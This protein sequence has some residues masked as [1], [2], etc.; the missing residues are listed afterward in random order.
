MVKIGVAAPNEGV[1]K[2]NFR[3]NLEPP[4]QI[5]TS[6]TASDIVCGILQA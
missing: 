1:A 2:Q 6:A 5:S 3:A 4:F